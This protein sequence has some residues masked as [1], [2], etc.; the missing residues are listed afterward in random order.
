MFFH[1]SCL[2]SNILGKARGHLS[3]SGTA[4]AAIFDSPPIGDSPHSYNLSWSVASYSPIT[5]FRLFF[6]PQPSHQRQIHHDI[7]LNS[8]HKMVKIF[9]IFLFL[10]LSRGNFN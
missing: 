3:L 9:F 6:R 2:A 7:D 5:E 8:V 1:F 10:F 4:A